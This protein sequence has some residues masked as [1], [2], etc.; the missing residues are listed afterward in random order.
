MSQDVVITYE[1]LYDILRREKMRAELQPL[2][3][4]FLQK[5]VKYLKEKQSIL[6]SQIKKVSVFSSSE[7][8]KTQKQIENIKRMVKELY[9]RREKKIIESALF[10]SRMNE[11]VSFQ[12]MLKEESILYEKLIATLNSFRKGVLFN[13]LTL[14]E[15]KIENEDKPKELKTENKPNNKLVRF[16]HAT[17]KFLGDD[18][19]V[20]GPFEEENIAALPLKAAKILIKN[21]RAEEIKIK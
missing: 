1:T 10:S 17:P 5:V 14:K 4:D 9:E 20:Y 12:E 3:K 15:P 2:D 16:I 19:K 7:T 18:L 8:Q 13:V 6:E 11:K 21:E